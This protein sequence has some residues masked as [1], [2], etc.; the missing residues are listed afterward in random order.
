MTLR[1]LTELRFLYSSVFSRKTEPIG[2]AYIQKE[3]YDK[4]LAH[5]IM[6]SGK[7]QDLQGASA[8]WRPRT[9]DG[10]VLV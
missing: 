5:V 7:S 2:C 8:S 4:E 10:L 3:I 9:A 6:E 1:F